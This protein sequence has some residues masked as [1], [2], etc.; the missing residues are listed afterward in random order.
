MKHVQ[1]D[2]SCYLMI[3]Q[4]LRG[5]WDLKQRIWNGVK[6]IISEW[7]GKTLVDTSLYGIRVY[8]DGAI[9][10]T[11]EYSSTLVRYLCT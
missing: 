11:R 2:K 9:L 10:A 1:V 8:R 6:P 3:L 5:G 7:T 4:S